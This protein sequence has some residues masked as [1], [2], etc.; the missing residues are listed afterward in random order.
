MPH[1]EQDTKGLQEAS[2]A[3]APKKAA[4]KKKAAP[5]K[6]AVAKK[7]TA[8]K[9]AAPK[10]AETVVKRTAA[11]RKT[12]SSASKGNG[13]GQGITPEVRLGMIAEA[14][15]Y[16]AERR[17]FQGGSPELDWLEAEAEVDQILS[18]G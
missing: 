14:A 7:A 6:K 10:K 17:G 18:A 2:A 15:Y 5:K 8:K 3:A 4:V 13:N 1:V 11:P 16:R 9:T 12:K